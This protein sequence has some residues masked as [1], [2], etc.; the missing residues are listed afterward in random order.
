MIGIEALWWVPVAAVVAMTAL[1]LLAATRRTT[2]AARQGWVLGLLIAGIAAT[3]LTAWQEV[4]NRA[5]LGRE[6]A[7][8]AEVG[9]RLDQLGTLLAQSSG[10]NTVGNTEANSSGSPAA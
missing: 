6:A 10:A 3:A 9:N 2:G 5:A 1:G 4:A 7:R 8:L